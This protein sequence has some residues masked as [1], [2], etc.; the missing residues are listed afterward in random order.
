M[1]RPGVG[2]VMAV[3]LGPATVDGASMNRVLD[4]TA[5]R[6]ARCAEG[7]ETWRWVS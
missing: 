5:E 6:F 1:V 7:R 2:R 3:V 4:L